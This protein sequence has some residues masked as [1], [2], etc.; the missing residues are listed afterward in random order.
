MAEVGKSWI[1]SSFADLLDEEGIREE[2][3]VQALKEVLTWQIE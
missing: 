2:A 3:E 1:G